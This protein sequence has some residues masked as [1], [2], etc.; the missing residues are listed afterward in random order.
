MS[1]RKVIDF[2]LYSS[3]NIALASFFFTAQAYWILEAPL[4]RNYVLFVFFS[5]LLVYS[6]HRIVGIERVKKFEHQGRFAVIKKYQNHIRIY[7]AIAVI[8]CC[9]FFF[10]FGLFEK[11]LII[12]PGILSLLYVLPIFPK[13]RRLRDFHGIKIFLIAFVWAWVAT[14]I[15]FTNAAFF[16][17]PISGIYFAEK[18][19]FILA[20]TIPFD[21]RDLEIDKESGVKTL[22]S[23]LGKKKAVQLTLILLIMHFLLIVANATTGFYDPWHTSALI[24]S[25]LLTL[26]VIQKSLRKKHDDWFSGWLDA[27]MILQ[28][29]L[30]AI[31]YYYF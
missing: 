18:F 4:D 19:I 7:T 22:A 6:V 29:F 16:P 20:I 1:F 26:F 14:V 30:I 23:L 24:V 2:Y 28:G 15:P 12:V 17:M 10:Q 5:T 8:M 13:N 31:V 3:F 25:N 27:T 21:I 9:Y 11:L